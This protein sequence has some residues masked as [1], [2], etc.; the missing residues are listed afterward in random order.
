MSF[1]PR[2]IVLFGTDRF[3][4]FAQVVVNGLRSSLIKLHNG[5]ELVLHAL[6]LGFFLLKFRCSGLRGSSEH[7]NWRFLIF[8]LKSFDSDLNF[9]NI[10]RR[11]GGLDA[12]S[13]VDDRPGHRY[14]KIS[15]ALFRLSKV[16]QGLDTFFDRAMIRRDTLIES[17]DFRLIAQGS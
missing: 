5:G 13:G 6:A 11:I 1:V 10:N 4:N 15:E 16:S 12:L 2:N 8:L 3:L 17:L 9:L 14:A 7:H